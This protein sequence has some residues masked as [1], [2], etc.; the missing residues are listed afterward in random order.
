MGKIIKQYKV[1]AFFSFIV[2][3]GKGFFA[4]LAGSFGPASGGVEIGSGCT[5]KVSE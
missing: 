1:C 4:F 2:A 3:S 5:G